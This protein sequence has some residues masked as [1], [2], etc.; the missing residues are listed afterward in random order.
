MISRSRR[1]CFLRADRYL[2]TANQ[3]LAEKGRAPLARQHLATHP[4]QLKALID[5]C[6]VWGLAVIFDV[7]YN[8]AGGDFGDESL[9]FFDRAINH[10][11]R[12]SLYFT[13]QGWAGGLVFD[14]QESSVRQFLIENARFYIDEYHA[15]GFRYDEVTVIDRFGGW[16][17]CQDLTDTLRFVKPSI[18]HIAEYWNPDQSWVLN[19]RA[20]EARASMPSG[21]IACAKPCAV[22]SRRLR[23]DAT[24]PSIWI[25]SH[26][27]SGSRWGSTR[28]GVQYNTSRITTSSMPLTRIASRGSPPSAMRRMRGR[29]THEAVR[30][31][32]LA[33]S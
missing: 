18:P 2:D 31:S 26:R 25:A 6:H 7:V 4:N 28:H 20:T 29:G 24:S 32:R 19:R 15:D 8:H 5:I 30:A 27:P 16:R 3:L 13:D 10:S 1:S 17:F 11:N 9:Y 12:D 23:T 14:F 33:S 22:R 21:A